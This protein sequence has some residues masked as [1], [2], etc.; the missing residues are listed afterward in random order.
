M[1][2]HEE[3]QHGTLSRRTFLKQAGA[4]AA[5]AAVGP[6]V[7]VRAAEGTTVGEGAHTYEWVDNW[8][9]LPKGQQFGYTHAVVEV[10]DG[11]IFVHNQSEDAVAIFDPD[12][13]YMGSWGKHLASGAHGMELNVEDGR[14]FLYLAPTGLHKC[15]KTTLDGEVVWEMEYPKQCPAYENGEQYVPTNIAIAANGD[16]YVADGYGLSWIHQY[17]KDAEYIRSWGGKG[18]EA[19]QMNCPHGIWVDT[20]GAA[21]R[22]VVADRANVRLQYFTLDGKHDGFVN[23]GLLYPC[24]FHQRNGELLIPDLHGRVTIFDKDNKPVAQ[25][26]E[27]PGINKREGYP[28][29][30]HEQREQ[31][32]FI[33]PHGACWDHAGNILVA[34][35]VNDGRVTKLR[36]VS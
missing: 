13:K 32:K 3:S 15:Y 27:N 33:S 28:N 20:R 9:T 14:E 8:A 17:N 24:H 7:L 30:P 19:G 21:P 16:F 34:E 11:R 1:N 12:G 2:A 6:N 5:L 23:D 29:L 4:G 35:W 26:G 18:S 22:L 31:G 36:R 25:L 10:S